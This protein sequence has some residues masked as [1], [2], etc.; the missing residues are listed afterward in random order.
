[1][2]G[3][4]EVYVL[5]RIDEDGREYEVLAVL[6]RAED[7]VPFMIQTRIEDLGEDID[8]WGKPE[9][10]PAGREI[11]LRDTLSEE[12]H[13]VWGANWIAEIFPLITFLEG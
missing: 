5:S 2:A 12:G 7:I 10:S 1:M 4:K 13:N 8:M 11:I 9:I 6:E 3:T